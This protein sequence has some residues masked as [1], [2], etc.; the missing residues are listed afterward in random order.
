MVP[1]TIA[2]SGELHARRIPAGTPHLSSTE[3]AGSLPTP[4]PAVLRVGSLV[5]LGSLAPGLAPRL[6]D[7]ADDSSV[8]REP[9]GGIPDAMYWA[10]YATAAVMLFVCAW[11]VSQRVRNYERGAPDD[12]RGRPGGRGGRAISLAPAHFHSRGRPG[13]GSAW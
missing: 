11:L 13:S 10:F 12:R 7:W 3:R 9:F 4:P 1:Q 2:L 8:T 5:A 6:T